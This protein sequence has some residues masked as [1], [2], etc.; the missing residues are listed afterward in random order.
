MQ[1]FDDMLVM[2]FSELIIV[3]FL[4]EILV[5]QISTI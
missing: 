3:M 4:F 1:L 2:S 5:E